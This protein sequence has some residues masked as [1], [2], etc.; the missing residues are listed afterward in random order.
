MG[1][2]VGDVELREGL[3]VTGSQQVAG[4]ELEQPFVDPA[5]GHEDEEGAHDEPN[6][7]WNAL[8]DGEVSLQPFRYVE[9][10]QEPAS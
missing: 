5:A 4:A 1:A 9:H 2:L 10:H 6:D 8:V 3:V 7:K